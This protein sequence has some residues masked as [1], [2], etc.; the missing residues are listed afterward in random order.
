[1]TI[2]C[3][4]AHALAAERVRADRPQ[5]DLPQHAVAAVDAARHI[6]SFNIAH[7]A[8]VEL[9]DRVVFWDGDGRVTEARVFVRDEAHFAVRLDARAEQPKAGAMA[10]RLPRDLAA[11]MRSWLPP[12]ATLW[13]RLDA[14]SPTATTAWIDGGLLDGFRVGDR[15]LIVRNDIPIGRMIAARV[16]DT[17]ALGTV[18]ALAANVTP[19][20]GDRVKLWPGPADRDVGRLES[21]ILLVKP[22]AGTDRIEVWLPGDPLDGVEKGQHWEIR[23]DGQYVDCVE[24]VDFRGRFAVGLQSAAFARDAIRV[25][26]AAVLRTAALVRTGRMPMRVFRREGNY[27][28]MNAGEDAGL[29]VGGRL[30]VV[31]DGRTLAELEIDT[32]KMDYCGAT[33]MKRVE[34]PPAAGG[35]FGTTRPAQVVE[36]AEW[37]TVVPVAA[38]GREAEPPPMGRVETVVNGELLI[39]RGEGKDAAVGPGVIVRLGTQPASTGIVVAV[40]GT[41]WVVYAP[42]SCAGA[43]VAVGCSV[44]EL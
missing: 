30:A 6:V 40:S 18:V 9:D 5:I 11:R 1:M 38:A 2:V 23:R 33:V 10:T 3:V 12:G 44:S 36:P 17:V 19:A 43:P 32:V 28:L 14:Q 4:L 29:E 22:V 27:C 37:D 42:P 34:S 21:R 20:P 7:G 16:Q 31:R 41:Q 13:A 24:I 35:P 8:G 15:L 26:D 39:V 25:G